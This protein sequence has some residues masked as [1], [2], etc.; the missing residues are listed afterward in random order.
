[1]FYVYI[2]A[3]RPN[4]TLYTGS[5]DDLLKRVV[6][7][8]EKLRGGFTAKYAVSRLVWYEVHDSREA[9]FVRERRIKE[10]RREWKLDLIERMNPEWADL[11]ETLL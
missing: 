2:L 3:S 8:R 5:T 11:F 10:W 9:A 7:H 4:G 6:E 1:M